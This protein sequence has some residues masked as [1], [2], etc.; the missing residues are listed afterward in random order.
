MERGIKMKD[1]F[2]HFLDFF[3]K[4]KKYF[5]TILVIFFSSFTMVFPISF[6]TSN[7]T[8]EKN[9]SLISSYVKNRTINKDYISFSIEER[10]IGSQSSHPSIASEYRS[11]YSLFSPEKLSFVATANGDKRYDVLFPQIDNESSFS[12][13]YAETVTNIE[14][15][16]HF[17]HEFYPLEFLFRGSNSPKNGAFSFCAISEEHANVL[18][19]EMD[20]LNY[21]DLIERNI[22][23]TISD[24]SYEFTIA[25]I[26]LCNNSFCNDLVSVFG[27]FIFTYSKIP[28]PLI[29]QKTYFFKP[30]VYQNMY[31]MDYIRENYKVGE[32]DT[33]VNHSNHSQ[34]IN[35]FEILYFLKHSNNVLLDSLCAVLLVFLSL[36]FAFFCITLYFYTQFSL[37]KKI[38][39]FG[40]CLIPYSIF[41]LVDILSNNFIFLSQLSTIMNFAFLITVL[42]L[43]LLIHLKEIRN[44][45]WSL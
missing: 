26:Y 8:K 3:I 17:K 15:G 18:L 21:E 41:A 32:I 37:K 6:L 45:K 1:K 30:Y 9:A 12:F 29:G 39:F 31:L 16:N 40:V 20:L 7:Y 22:T 10:D 33:F 13:L 27:N 11:L 24:F 36:I 19:K 25:N 43:L 2:L 23:M 14:Y 4:R 5:L 34:P 38:L 28:S 44:T 42:I 35:D